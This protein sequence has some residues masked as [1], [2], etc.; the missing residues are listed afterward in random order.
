MTRSRSGESLKDQL[1]QTTHRRQGVRFVKGRLSAD[2]RE[3]R[4]THRSHTHAH[5]QHLNHSPSL[6]SSCATFQNCDN[7]TFHFEVSIVPRP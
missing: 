6:I 3:Q 5:T 2:G 4:Y 1:R 7:H